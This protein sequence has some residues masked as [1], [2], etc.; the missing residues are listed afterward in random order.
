MP[1]VRVRGIYATAIAKILIDRGVQLV[2]VSEKIKERFGL[3]V[4][5]QPC[6]VTIKTTEDPDELLIVGFPEQSRQVYEVLVEELK[7]VYTWKSGVELH[8]VYM[9]VVV[10]KQGEFCIV[11]IGDARGVLHPCR[12]EVGSRVLVGVRKPPVKPGEKLLLTRSFRIVGEYVAIIHGESKVTF[13]EHITDPRTKARLTAIAA[14][15]LM[16]SGVGVH[17][18]SSSKYASDDAVK[19][20][21]ERLLEEYR[22][23]VSRARELE[24]STPVK[25][26]SGEFIAILS[27]TSLAKSLL[28]EIRRR[29]IF[30]VDKHH[31]LK[32]LGLSDLVDLAE[33]VASK[34]TTTPDTRLSLAEYVADKISVGD[35][36][37]VVHVKPTGEVITLQPGRVLKSTV[38]NGELVLVVERYMKSHGVYDGLGIEKRPGD[39]DYMIVDTRK[40]CISH[41]Y[42]RNGNWL[43]SY[44][45][46]NTP[47]EIA[48]GRIKYHDLLVD[49]VVYPT[50]ELK[51]VDREEL[52]NALKEGLVTRP[53]Y[54]FAV[55]TVEEIK[56]NP[57]EYTYNPRLKN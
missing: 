49:V 3:E 24:S 5:E 46:V 22:T 37:E 2:D 17:F 10:D 51:V 7:Y 1:R 57:Y 11:D 25:L 4:E 26:R 19:N 27:L 55:K 38:M 28:D 45:N 56:A 53:L 13:S 50:G 43:G 33:Y 40:P 9:G 20:D 31:S 47:P 32:S 42:F 34:T 36:V 44:I 6:D 21:I 30:T 18:R 52:E 14:S 23:L 48:P 39:V 12:E 35:S 29:V 41:N 8:A 16:G 54:E 15:K